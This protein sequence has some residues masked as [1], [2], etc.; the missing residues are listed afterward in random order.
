VP[1][2]ERAHR[3]KAPQGQRSSVNVFCQSQ[4]RALLTEDA[5]EGKAE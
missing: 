5:T 1:G 2:Q 4:W 3:Q